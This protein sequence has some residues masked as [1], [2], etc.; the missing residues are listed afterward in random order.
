MGGGQNQLQIRGVGGGGGERGGRRGLL[1]TAF[2]ILMG[3]LAGPLL[4]CAKLIWR[5]SHVLYANATQGAG[6]GG[7]MGLEAQQA[8]R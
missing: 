5:S 8:G 7:L 6:G 4:N 1:S 2:T 3:T